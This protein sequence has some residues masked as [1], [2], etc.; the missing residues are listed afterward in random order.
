MRPAAARCGRCEHT[1]VPPQGRLIDLVPLGEVGGAAAV[2]LG[3]SEGSAAWTGDSSLGLEAL[4]ETIDRA[5]LGLQ[6]EYDDEDDAPSAEPAVAGQQAGGSRRFLVV[7]LAGAAA[8]AVAIALFSTSP[9]P[10]SAPDVALPAAAQ[11]RFDA[12][13]ALLLLD[14]EVSLESAAAAFD[15]A[16]EFAPGHASLQSWRALATALL[17]ASLQDEVDEIE[18]RLEND[19]PGGQAGTDLARRREV[20][21]TRIEVLDGTI[22][23]FAIDADPA[24][25]KDAAALALAELVAGRPSRAVE[26]AARLETEE[27]GWAALVRAMVAARGEQPAEEHASAFELMQVALEREPNLVRARHEQARL[28][29]AKNPADVA[30]ARRLIAE[31]RTLSPEHEGARRLSETLARAA[32]REAAAAMEVAP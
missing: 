25:G 10:Q 29:L 11:A 27:G 26:L 28:A 6:V 23:G 20:L 4:P 14:D 13:H 24:G 16:I 2:A 22:R 31:V 8:V 32:A 17:A 18:E 1:F 30:S 3:R 12:G 7:A 5:A 9:E 21:L 19:R 15:D